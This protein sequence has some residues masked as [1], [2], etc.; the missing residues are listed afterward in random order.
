MAFLT[1]GGSSRNVE[2]QDVNP[3]AIA[4]RHID[5]EAIED[6]HISPDW[7][8]RGTETGIPVSSVGLKERTV[9]LPSSYPT[10]LDQCLLTTKNIASPA[11]TELGHLGVSS[12]TVSS[13]QIEMLVS[14]S[15][16]A[17]GSVSIDWE[18]LGKLNFLYA[19]T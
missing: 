6:K 11:T 2:G 18:T 3:S 12:L 15:A 1:P 8:Q 13:F 9:S 7:L 5:D 14:V 4:S 19:H 16:G 10:S 17:T